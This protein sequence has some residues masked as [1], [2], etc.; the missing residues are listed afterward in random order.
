MRTNNKIVGGTGDFQ[1]S[2]ETSLKDNLYLNVNGK[3]LETAEIPAD[4]PSTGG[5][6]DLRDEV[7]NKLQKDLAKFT[8]EQEDI[9]DP[10]LKEAVKLYQLAHDY[11]RRNQEGINPA[12]SK[13]KFY[14]NLKD[15]DDIRTNIK[16]LVLDGSFALTFWVSPNMK[17]TA[18]NLLYVGAPAL[19]L[20]DKQYY[21]TPSEKVLIPVLQ[22]MSEQVLTAY[23]ESEGSAKQIIQN[24]I[25]FD[26]MLVPLVM[27]SEEKADY[28]TQYNPVDFEQ[29]KSDTAY[30]NL[31]QVITELGETT[32]KIVSYT[33]PRYI[34]QLSKIISET[35]FAKF[36]DWMLLNNA[37]SMT[38]YLSDELRIMGG[39][40][41]RALNG[42]KEASNQDKSAYQITNSIFSEILGIYY[43]D[44][45]FGKKAREDVK[46]MVKAM[47]KVYKKR[48]QNNTW[49]S[50]KTIKKA[51]AKLDAMKLKIGYPDQPR[52]LYQE[53]KVDSKASLYQNI[54]KFSEILVRD[55]FKDLSRP[56]DRT[57]WDMPGNLVNACY[58]PHVNDITF[59]AAILQKPFYSLEQSTSQNY[60]G[61][62]AVIAHEISHGF[63][64]NGAK[65]D[66]SGNMNNWWT[67]EDYHEF[68]KRCQGMINELDGVKFGSGKVNGKLVVSE[69]VAD[70]GGLSCAL[71]AAKQDPNV[72][73]V[74]FFKNWARIWQTKSSSAFIEMLLTNDVHAPAPLRANVQ[75]QNID[76]FYTTFNVTEGD[77]MWL[78]KSERVAI[79]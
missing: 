63:D 57:R 47:V 23:G 9:T 72:D 73:L 11:D 62:G 51:V 43:G 22:K 24:A 60:G 44:K 28:T 65:F 71:E 68:K 14:K 8:Q 39:I 13:Y 78:P 16:Q 52:E 2:G 77:G 19:F 69:S 5:F 42:T 27:S 35:N 75:A 29:F 10:Y 45:Y 20:P 66:E 55:N 54:A 79:W 76:E 18:H 70:Q 33:E 58:D 21:G 40:F 46:T 26:K 64:N 48:L 37:I 34:E 36:H 25:D 67:K 41:S 32:P 3:W 1:N 15:L 59:P 31:A 50:D 12:L 4:R 56:V 30:F 17:D 61:I 74:E 38:P 7:D 49:L 53:L 6:S